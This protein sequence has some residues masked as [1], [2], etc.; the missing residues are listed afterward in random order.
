MYMTIF[1]PECIVYTIIVI[2]LHI[3]TKTTD[4][5]AQLVVQYQT[6]DF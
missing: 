3:W 4:T 5:S 2:S 6:D 1:F